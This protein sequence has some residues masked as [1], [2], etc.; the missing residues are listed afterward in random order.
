MK[1]I[2][3]S[4]LP[5]YSSLKGLFTIGTDSNNRSVKVS[6]EFVEDET[7]KAVAK[8]EEATA[9]ALTAKAETETATSEARTATSEAQTATEQSLSQ[10]A[11]ANTATVNANTAAQSAL[12][13]KQDA[14]EA[15]AAALT[16][17]AETETA[18]SEARTATSEAQTAT[19]QSLSQTA[20]A[21]TATVNANTAAQS[22]LEAKQDAE[23]ATAAAL[24]AKAETET[25][26]SE[27]RIVKV[28][29]QAMLDRLVPTGLTVTAPERLTVT[30][31]RPVYIQA[32]LTPTDALKNIIYIS[33]NK[34]VEVSLS[35]Q[36]RV[37]AE[38]KSVVSVIPT[39]NTSLAKSVLIEVCKPTARLYT[40]KTLRLTSGGGFLFT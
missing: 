20:L 26:T 34:A 3:I 35:G 5:L 8:A 33:D 37:V 15:T 24:T 28:D 23:E 27:A 38:G 2:K 17:K 4:E 1:K 31:T 19:E 6:L 14:E 13:A 22:A 29:I 10:T 18:T 32:D 11:L 25:A 16:A 40:A 12:E 36:L 30:N 7:N 21:N 9:A 39:C